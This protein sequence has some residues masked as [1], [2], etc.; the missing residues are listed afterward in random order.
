MDN[1]VKK[2]SFARGSIYYTNEATKI[3]TEIACDK[4]ILRYLIDV[5]RLNPSHTTSAGHLQ[6]NFFSE[7]GKNIVS[8]FGALH[9]SKGDLERMLVTLEMMEEE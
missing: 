5:G 8:S 2:T 3:K 9:F 4:G 1:D 7:Q 6:R